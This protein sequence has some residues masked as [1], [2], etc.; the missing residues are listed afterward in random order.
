MW[1][2]GTMIYIWVFNID[3]FP[4]KYKIIKKLKSVDINNYPN[5]L[6]KFYSSIEN[7]NSDGFI[8]SDKTDE[9]YRQ[10]KIKFISEH[11]PD[12]LK[13][14]MDIFK[15]IYE[16]TSIE[17]LLNSDYLKGIKKLYLKTRTNDT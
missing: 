6:R 8:Q 15:P 13:F 11:F 9:Y 1:M 2:I 3:P 7:I 4:F 5:I 14:M 17:T 16:R 10:K 12:L